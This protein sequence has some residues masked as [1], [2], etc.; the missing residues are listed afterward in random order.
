[1]KRFFMLLAAAAFFLP[2]QAAPQAYLLVTAKQARALSIV[3]AK[4][5]KV[6]AQ[7]PLG[8]DPHEIVIA[9]DNR[10]AYVSHWGQGLLKTISVVDLVKGTPVSEID[11]SPLQGP[12]GMVLRGTTLW[13]TADRSKAL[14]TLDIATGKVTAVLGGGQ[15]MTHMMWLSPDASKILASNA[16][17]GTFSMFDKVP[18]ST[19]GSW[20]AGYKQTLVPVGDG[21]E[22]FAVSPDAREV[23]VGNGDGRIPVIDMATNKVVETI[24]AGTVQANRL[25]FTPDGKYVVVTQKRGPDL[26]VIDAKTHAIVKRIPIEQNGASGIQFQPDGSRVFIACPRDHYV[27]VV[28][29]KKMKLVGKIDAGREPDGLAWWVH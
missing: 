6:T 21:A 29:L 15:D 2:A 8:V 23:W 3:D 28:D 13:F 22:G 4:T 17:S 16:R 10:T 12:H 19:D 1:M 26:V 9:P 14:A 7:I 25:A 24:E 18:E 11:I 5:L 20:S 27:A